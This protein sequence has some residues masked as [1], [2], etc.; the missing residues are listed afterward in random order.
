VLEKRLSKEISFWEKTDF[1]LDWELDA[2]NEFRDMPLLTCNPLD[3]W[4]V[5]QSREGNIDFLRFSVIKL[6]DERP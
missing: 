6:K 3:C 5:Q 4:I 1:E 2:E